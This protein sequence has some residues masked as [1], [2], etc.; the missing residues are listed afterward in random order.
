M[1]QNLSEEVRECHA[2]SKDCACKGVAQS[3]P[4]VR[5]SFLDAQQAWLRLTRRLASIPKLEGN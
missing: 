4:A 1:L 3:D 2:H 5:Q